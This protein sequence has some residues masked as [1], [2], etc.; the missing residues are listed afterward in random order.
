M[1]R[2]AGQP[3][4]CLGRLSNPDPAT[5]S[6]AVE[7]TQTTWLRSGTSPEVWCASF[8]LSTNIT[9]WSSIGPGVRVAGGWQSPAMVRMPNS[10]I[11]ARG[12]VAGSSDGSSW[13]V[14]NLARVGP[15]IEAENLFSN[16]FHLSIRALPGDV[17]VIEASS[18]LVT[19]IALQTNSVT[20][21]SPIVFFDA[22]SS[23]F[24]ARFY[25]A[26]VK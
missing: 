10:L 12:L 7:A 15:Q 1:N 14:E 11:R 17:L 23:N 20:D 4:S 26:R 2:L 19:W 22:E 24:P 21:L 9:D 13:V 8:D 18:N 3:R 25:R 16:S 5:Q 6:L